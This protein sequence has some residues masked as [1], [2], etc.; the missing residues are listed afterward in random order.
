MDYDYEFNYHQELLRIECEEYYR[1]EAE[2]ARVIEE[3]IAE[4]LGELDD[5][6]Y[7]LMRDEMRQRQKVRDIIEEILDCDFDEDDFLEGGF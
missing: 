6:L 7:E 4:V 3:V 1:N 5:P 2:D